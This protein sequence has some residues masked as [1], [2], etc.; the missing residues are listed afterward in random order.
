MVIIGPL[1]RIRPVTVNGGC[2]SQSWAGSGAWKCTGAPGMSVTPSMSPSRWSRNEKRRSSPSLTTSSPQ[3]SC[4]AIAWSTARSSIRL[5][6]V[7]LIRPAASAA[8]AS[9]R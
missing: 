6:S 5:N 1:G 9:E 7:L 8:R 4:M 2:Q 3:P